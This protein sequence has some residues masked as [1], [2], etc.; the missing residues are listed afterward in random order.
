M[1]YWKIKNKKNETIKLKPINLNS[2][3]PTVDMNNTVIVDFR[4]EFEKLNFIK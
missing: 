2:N 1:I 4:I 3:A